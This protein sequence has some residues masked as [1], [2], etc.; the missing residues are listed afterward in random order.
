LELLKKA[1]AS[2]FSLQNEMLF[3]GLAQLTLIAA[4]GFGF[5]AF[6][7]ALYILASLI[8]ILLLETINY[9]EHYG[10]LRR[11]NESGKYER[12]QHVHSWNSDYPLGRLLLFE[13]PRHSDHHYKASK[14]YQFLESHDEAPQLP[15]GYP[16]MILLSL[17]PP[18]WFAVMDNRISEQGGGL[19]VVS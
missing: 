14:K 9:V 3:M 18:L 1:N 19:S 5:G 17:V 8:G 15:A 13:L 16:A 6:P 4:V 12:V 11:M 7:M 2:F 10:L